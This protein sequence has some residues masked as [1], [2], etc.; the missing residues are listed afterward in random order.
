MKVPPRRRRA[1][2]MQVG[3]VIHTATATV[4]TLDG[5]VQLYWF[6]VPDGMTN[7][8]AFTTQELHGPFATDAE[9]RADGRVVLLPNC[10]ITEGGMWDPA[11]DRPQ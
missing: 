8:E 7:E 2:K 9:A 4:V 3:T 10:K 1:A 5:E 11:W 6:V